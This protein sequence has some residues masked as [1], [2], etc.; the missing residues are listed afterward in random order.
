MMHKGSK[1]LDCFIHPV[2]IISWGQIACVIVNLCCNTYISLNE[3]LD[4]DDQ[5]LE[6]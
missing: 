6:N 5:T 4:A 3:N 1:E 2:L